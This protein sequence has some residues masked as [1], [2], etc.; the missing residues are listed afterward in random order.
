MESRPQRGVLSA[1][2]PSTMSEIFGP[3]LS[4]DL[5]EPS[6][7]YLRDQAVGLLGWTLYILP[8]RPYQRL[9]HAGSMPEP[10]QPNLFYRFFC[11]TAWTVPMSGMT[12][13]VGTIEVA[14][15]AT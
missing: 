4:L 3:G 9:V 11:R 13:L 8:S 5:L 1:A 10:R 14:K 12:S 15:E 2:E 7:R 6:G